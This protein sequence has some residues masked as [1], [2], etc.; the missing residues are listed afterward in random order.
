MKK[1]RWGQALIDKAIADVS[2]MPKEEKERRLKEAQAV[3]DRFRGEALGYYEEGAVEKPKPRVRF[4]NK[5]G[6]GV[7][8]IETKGMATLR[9]WHQS[10]KG[11]IYEAAQLYTKQYRD[12][13]ITG[14]KW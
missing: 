5:Y 3:A 10:L 14:K 11:A 1:P 12:H 6:F 13:D 4:A 2:A 9:A 7:W 8:I